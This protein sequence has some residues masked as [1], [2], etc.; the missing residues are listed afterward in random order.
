MERCQG[1]TCPG[2]VS[3][4]SYAPHPILG[5]W[6][7]SVRILTLFPVASLLHLK[8]GKEVSGGEIHQALRVFLSL[9]SD[10]T[11]RVKT[12]S[13]AHFLC[14]WWRNM[15][16]LWMRVGSHAATPVSLLNFLVGRGF[17]Q[18]ELGDGSPRPP[19]SSPLPECPALQSRQEHWSF[20]FI[21]SLLLLLWPIW[22]R[23]I[24]KQDF[25]LHLPNPTVWI[26]QPLV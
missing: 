23:K 8:I 18:A 21:F 26:Y 19:V 7:V 12:Q 20:A 24:R 17:D 9:D 16:P 5:T 10:T 13:K 22:G 6:S 2:N 1:H 14:F 11:L 3:L 25:S 15:Q 4:T